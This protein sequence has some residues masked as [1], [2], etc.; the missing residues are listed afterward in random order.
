MVGV[1]GSCGDQQNGRR[2]WFLRRS[3]KWA[4]RFGRP[5]LLFDR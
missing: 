3:A 4:A 2:Y 1:T 5:F